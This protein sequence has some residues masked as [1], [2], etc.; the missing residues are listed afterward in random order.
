MLTDGELMA[1]ETGTATSEDV[2]RRAVA[3]L[4]ALRDENKT[5]KELMLINRDSST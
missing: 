1:I 3:E 5:L 2:Y 4:L